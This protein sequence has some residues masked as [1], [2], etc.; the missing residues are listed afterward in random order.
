M[1]R[2]WLTEV[3]ME[4]IEKTTKLTYDDRRKIL[5]QNKT[6]VQKNDT[7]E[8]IDDDGKVTEKSK[9]LSTV[10]QSMTVEYTEEGI[11]MA[12]KNLSEEFSFLENQIA[13]KKKEQDE[14]GEMPDEIKKV[15]EQLETLA[16][17]QK[18]DAAKEEYSAMKDRRKEVKTEMDELKAEIGTRLKL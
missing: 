9:L 7:P 10:N 12:Y 17:Y 2:K 1:R 15:K 11:K 5:I 14:L 4:E 3:K 16:K 8:V 13:K 6:Q 18:A